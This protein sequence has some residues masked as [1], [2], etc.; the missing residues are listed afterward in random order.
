M[1]NPD[2]RKACHFFSEIRTRCRRGA[3]EMIFAEKRPIWGAL[4]AAPAII[5][6]GKWAYK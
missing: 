2:N 4:A 1:L 6:G 5:K 3:E